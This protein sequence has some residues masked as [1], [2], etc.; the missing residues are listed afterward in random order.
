MV[1]GSRRARPTDASCLACAAA[2]AV[3]IAEARVRAKL[4]DRFGAVL[5]Q[6][7]QPLGG[8]CNI[9]QGRSQLDSF[10]SP[11]SP[12]RCPCSRPPARRCPP[13]SSPP[14]ATLA[15]RGRILTVVCLI[16][17]S[18]FPSNTFLRDFPGFIARPFRGVGVGVGEPHLR[19]MF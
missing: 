17:V 12:R 18:A 16:I 3:A 4:E 14:P 2:S 9:H 19:F 11:P 7:A 5:R 15:V 8:G 13:L 1:E 6:C 10:L